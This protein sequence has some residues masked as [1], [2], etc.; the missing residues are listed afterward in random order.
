VTT[1][2]LLEGPDLERLVEQVRVEFGSRAR[3]VRAERVRTGGFA[4]FFARE[5]FEMTVDVPD[6]PSRPAR[7]VGRAGRAPAPRAAGLEDLL[8]AADAADGTG[9][10]P[11]ADDVR[12]S[13]ASQEFAAVLDQV[14]T[15]VGLPVPDVAAPERAAALAVPAAAAARGADAAPGPGTALRAELTRLGVPARLLGTGPVTLGAVLGRLPRP[16]AP[17]RGPGQR[18]VV[19]GEGDGPHAVVRT[20]ALRWGVPDA[21]VHELEA[22]GAVVA[23]ARESAFPQVVALRVGPEH[24]DRALAARAL[25]T[26]GGDQVW[27]VTDARTKP[28]DVA[29]WVAAVG[30]ER[31]VDALAVH[32]LLETAAPG[33]VLEP[34]LPVAW[35]DGVPASRLVWAAALGQELEAA[36]T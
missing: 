32:G 5:H 27:A 13:T 31:P 18:L 33:T 3:I 19:V 29:A 23:P 4:G 16:A 17:P 11:G 20:L 24:H 14:R 25:A 6:E 35:V 15:L 9:E 26:L 22:V 36:L 21:C 7:T 8:D 30:A 2:L 28:A 12:V 34:G 1:R 10:A